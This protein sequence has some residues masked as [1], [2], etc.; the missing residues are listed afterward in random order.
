MVNNTYIDAAKLSDEAVNK[1]YNEG[2]RI[3]LSR[4]RWAEWILSNNYPPHRGA[5]YKDGILVKKS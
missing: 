4:K 3:L 1:H 5:S 2:Y